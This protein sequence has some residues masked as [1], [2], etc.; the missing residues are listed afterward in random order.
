MQR[1][2]LFFLNK[3]TSL[4]NYC[5]KHS[6]HAFLYFWINLRTDL[7]ACFS[8]SEEGHSHSLGI[9][10]R[11]D[12]TESFSSSEE[13]H[14][15]S[16]DINSRTDLSESFSSSEEGHSH[17]F[18]IIFKASSSIHF[19]TTSVGDW[20]GQDINFKIL[21]ICFAKFTFVLNRFLVESFLQCFKY[22]FAKS[23]ATKC[24]CLLVCFFM[25][26]SIWMKSLLN[27]I[28]EL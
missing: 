26:P 20:G 1:R 21:S 7:S 3:T 10:L 14:S 28:T 23:N 12:L 25:I 6:L 15:Y 5:F 4:V 24:I 18:G 8:S 19:Y 22:V 16:L 11:T 17:S 27:T 13:G 9:T 2:H